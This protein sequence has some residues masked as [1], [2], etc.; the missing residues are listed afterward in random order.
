MFY[1]VFQEKY[2]PCPFS[3]EPQADG[4][5]F[6]TFMIEH[7]NYIIVNIPMIMTESKLQLDEISV[8]SCRCKAVLD[9]VNLRIWLWMRMRIWLWWRWSWLHW[10]GRMHFWY[11]KMWRKCCMLELKRKELNMFFLR[12]DYFMEFGKNL[13]RYLVALAN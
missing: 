8:Y 2:Q 12:I 1:I 6:V 10:H 13:S 11:C 5:V 7:K 9:F 4:L 3:S